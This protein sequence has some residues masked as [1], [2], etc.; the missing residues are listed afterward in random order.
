MPRKPKP[1]TNWTND[2]ALR[3]LFPKRVRDWLKRKAH[4]KDDVKQPHEPKVA[5]G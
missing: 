5:D 4:E 3:R 1:P 2:E